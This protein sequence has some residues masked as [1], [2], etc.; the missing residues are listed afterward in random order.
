MSSTRTFTVPM[1]SPDITAEERA[2]VAR[3]LDTTSLSIGPVVDAFEQA[4]A[5]R[6]GA[7]HAVAVCNGTAAL[8][9][10][11]I[12]AGVQQGDLVVT[13]P[14]S[15]VAS[16]NVVLYERAIPVFVDVDADTGNVRPDLVNEALAD[17]ARG[18][19][20]AR[21]WLPPNLR[22]DRV[23]PVKAVLPVH[24]FGQPA[25]MD[26]IVAAA[27]VN[28]VTVIED[29]CEAI[30]AHYRGRPAGGLGD[31]GAFAFYPNKQMTT[32]EG[33]MLFTSRSDWNT[34]ARSLR[35]QGRDVHGGWLDH[36]RLGYNYRLDEMSAALGLAQL[37]RL[38]DLL[39]RRQRVAAWYRERLTNVEE[40]VLPVTSAT[41][42]RESSFVFVVRLAERLDRNAII[43]GLAARGIPSRPYFAPIHQQPFYVARFGYRSEAFPVCEAWGRSALA[44]PFSS[45]MTVDQVDVVCRELTATIHGQPVR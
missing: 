12:L 34:L 16:A 22:D 33:G 36:A 41:T 28:N 37:E 17:L 30:G 6:V 31:V 42:T 26:P 14:F 8:H 13:T 27:S 5:A 43:K 25:D 20:A 4:F 32:G 7:R 11:V 1:S 29:A 3:V 2:A 21:Q 35:N 23:G 38:D 18:G 24:A 9:L 19:K 15:F 44:L 40:V 45:V 10:A 39:A